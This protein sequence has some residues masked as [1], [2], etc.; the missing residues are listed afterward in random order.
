MSP[1]I[2]AEIGVNHNGDIRLAK[3]LVEE[4]K[5]CGA[6]AVKFQTFVTEKVVSKAAPLADYQK[7]DGISTQFQLLKS[8]ELT[9]VEF[10]EIKLYCDQLGIKFLSTP[11]D[12]ESLIFLVSG[13]KH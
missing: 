9:N 6:N 13:A 7:R 5:N 3:K 2:I 8:L 4:A 11:D 12:L 10:K 1:F